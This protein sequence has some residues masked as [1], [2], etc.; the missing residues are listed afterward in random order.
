MELN[1]LIFP[2][3]PASYSFETHKSALR[4]IPRGLVSPKGVTLFGPE[5]IEV[6]H[7]SHI[8]CLF[9]PHIAGSNKLVLYFHDHSEDL[10]KVVGFLS[11]LSEDLGAHVIAAEYPGYGIY[12]GRPRAKRVCEDAVNVYDYVAFCLGWEERNIVLL[13]RGL[14]SGP[15]VHIAA[16]RSPGAVVLLSGFTSIKA[17]I[18]NSACVLSFFMAD[19]FCNIDLMPD[20]KSPTLFIHGS[21]DVLVPCKFSEELY[22]KCGSETKELALF[23]DMDHNQIELRRHLVLPVERFLGK[24]GWTEA[25]KAK[26]GQLVLPIKRLPKEFEAK[27]G[28]WSCGF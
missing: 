7:S 20:V 27:A 13:G 28:R 4:F 25:E 5:P 26:K 19:K 11:G 9:L 17:V 21:A 16:R 18:K 14:G 24:L 12:S 3:P 1:S 23:E 22:R 6:E 8:P 15:A 10:G 2:A